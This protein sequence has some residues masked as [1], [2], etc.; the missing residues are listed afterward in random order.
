MKATGYGYEQNVTKG[1][2]EKCRIVWYWQTGK[3]KLKDTRCKICGG[4][5]RPTTKY[6]KRFAWKKYN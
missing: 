1:K 5:L 2:C 3:R 6:M 4:R